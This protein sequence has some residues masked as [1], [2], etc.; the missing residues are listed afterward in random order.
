MKVTHI[1][2]SLDMG[3]AQMMLYKLIASMQH[4]DAEVISL[5]ENGVIGEKISALGAPVH[6]LNM[7]PGLPNP[8]SVTRLC[9]LLKN[10]A[11]DIVQTWMYH[12]DLVGGMATRLVGRIPIVWGIRN[13]TLDRRKTKRTTRWTVQACARFSHSIPRR[14]ISC[15]ESSL[16]LH[17]ELGYAA[18][19]MVVIPNGFDLDL[20][21]PSENARIRLRQELG[22]SHASPLIGHVG[23]FDPQKD[24]PTL[25]EAAGRLHQKM[26]QV[27]FVLCGKDIE[28]KNEEL[29]GWITD[30]GLWDIF[31]LLGMRADM[32]Q[33]MAALDL[34]TLTSAYG[35]AF[36]NVVGEAMACEVPC[37]V[38]DVGD[39]A[40]LVGDSGRVVP[41]REPGILAETWEQILQM[42]QPKRAEMGQ[43]ARQ[44][45]MEKFSLSGVAQQYEKVYTEVLQDM[46]PH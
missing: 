8:L 42:P 45:I 11:P 18:E 17:V 31:H 37:V 41:L 38:T 44:R 22:V 15:S 46:Q 25:I 28:W 40:Y 36:P 33:L 27:H 3:G 16:S 20:Y 14:I 12:A 7:K 32:P 21:Q 19:K 26:P 30:R 10:I 5:R 4:V 9:R 13:S 2:T 1:I 34:F 6:Y 29:A 24:Y 23:R 43:T 39:S 35:E